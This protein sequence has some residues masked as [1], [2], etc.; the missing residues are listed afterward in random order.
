MNVT[1]VRK[2][3]QDH[4]P[5]VLALKNGDAE[6]FLHVDGVTAVNFTPDGASGEYLGVDGRKEVYLLSSVV[7][8]FVTRFHG[9][10]KK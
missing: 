1:L 3:E 4:G 7:A 2:E 10:G 6:L 8:Q 9:A 5:L